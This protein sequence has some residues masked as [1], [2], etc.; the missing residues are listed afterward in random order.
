ME[1]EVEAEAERCLRPAVAAV[2]LCLHRV[3][4]VALCLH[5][6]A[7]VLCRRPGLD[8]SPC[9]S[10]EAHTHPECTRARLS[11]FYPGAKSDAVSGV[12]T[13]RHKTF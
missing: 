12:A 2:A 11:G 8:S 5:R 4:V 9:A 7:A 13:H 10:T 6:L 3:A 1:A